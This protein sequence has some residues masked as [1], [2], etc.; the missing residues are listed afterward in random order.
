[1]TTRVENGLLTWE[2]GFTPEEETVV[3]V[4]LFYS[5]EVIHYRPAIWEELKW[6]WIQYFALF[7]ALAYVARYITKFVFVNRYVHSYVILP[8]EDK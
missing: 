1:M 4:E 2:R 3:Q 8:W 7:F 5:E 6:A